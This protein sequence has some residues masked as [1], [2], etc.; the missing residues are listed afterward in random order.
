MKNL[1]IELN[2]SCVYENEN[3]IL[4]LKLNTYKWSL[5]KIKFQNQTQVVFKWKC[6]S[7]ACRKCVQHI[8]SIHAALVISIPPFFKASQFNNVFFQSLT[9]DAN[10]R[11][12]I[13]VEIGH[14]QKQLCDQSGKTWKFQ[15]GVNFLRKRP[16]NC[17]CS[18][19]A[20]TF[21]KKSLMLHLISWIFKT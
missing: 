16:L 17:G 19:L 12:R 8:F 13:T 2:T 9:F 4:I 6:T 1:V 20:K 3:W 14:Q 15:F 21:A 5:M 18:L 7:C 10:P 11:I